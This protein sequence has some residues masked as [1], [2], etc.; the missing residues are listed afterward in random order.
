MKRLRGPMEGMVL[1]LAGVG[2]VAA[3]IMI[4]CAAALAFGGPEDPLLSVFLAAGVLL[5]IVGL[6]G[7]SIR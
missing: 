5:A 2:S 7:S 4:A 1:V 6:A 3:A